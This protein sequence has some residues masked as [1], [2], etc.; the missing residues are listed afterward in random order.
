MYLLCSELERQVK[1]QRQLRKRKHKH[2]DEE[3]SP[4]SEGSDDEERGVCVPSALILTFMVTRL[5]AIPLLLL[6]HFI[7]KL[8]LYM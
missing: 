4:F 8:W 2:D 7:T 5:V 1:T 3:E 6:S